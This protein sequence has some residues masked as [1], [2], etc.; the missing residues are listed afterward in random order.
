MPLR[1]RELSFHG[2]PQYDVEWLVE[3]S[4]LELRCEFRSTDQETRRPVL[5]RLRARLAVGWDSGLPVLR[6]VD[7]PGFALVRV[8]SLDLAVALDGERVF[9]VVRAVPR[10]DGNS[11]LVPDG[12]GRRAR[13]TDIV[14]NIK[15]ALRH[16]SSTHAAQPPARPP[17]R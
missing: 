16:L 17:L 1:G 8:E 4:R 12:S 9:D 11:L 10:E 7:P 5:A 2:R 14:T 15:S 3:G 13:I 6:W